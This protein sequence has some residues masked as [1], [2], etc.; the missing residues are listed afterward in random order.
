MGVATHCVS[1]KRRAPSKPVL[2]WLFIVG[3]SVGVVGAREAWRVHRSAV[4][5]R[6]QADLWLKT[7]DSFVPPVY[8]RRADEL[9]SA[10]ERRTIARTLRAIV[11]AANTSCAIA[12]TINRTTVRRHA[13]AI[14]K[15]A[16]RLQDTTRPVT[17]A[18]MLLATR[19]I[20]DPWSALISDPQSQQL[21][22]TIERTIAVL[23]PLNI[24]R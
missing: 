7:A 21:A 12:G 13:A 19:L 9:C 14:N 16:A 22:D 6:R 18:G 5:R 24:R 20:T 4:R 1:G 3:A 23:E 2:S 17:P 11:A 10:K 8:R 15:L